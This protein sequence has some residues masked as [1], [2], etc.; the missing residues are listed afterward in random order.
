MRKGFS[1]T[2]YSI[3]RLHLI[4]NNIMAG[5]PAEIK[6]KQLRNAYNNQPLVL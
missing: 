3:R 1:K 6:V 2:I 5:F 4:T